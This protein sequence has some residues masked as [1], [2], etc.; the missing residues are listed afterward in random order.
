MANKQPKAPEA[1]APVENKQAEDTT[2][3]TPMK[4]DANMKAAAEKETPVLANEAAP[5][6]ADSVVEGDKPP[7]KLKK[8]ETYLGNGSIM[9]AS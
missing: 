5:K 3:A 6:M 4:P 9:V 2:L 8:G 7:R 1:K